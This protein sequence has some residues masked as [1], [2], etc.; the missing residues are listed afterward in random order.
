MP[1]QASTLL[2]PAA[3]SYQGL[4]PGLVGLYQFNITVPNVPPGDYSLTVTGP[5]QS[6]FI[7]VGN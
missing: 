2:D 4:T 6:L 7:T 5:S 3:V 1:D